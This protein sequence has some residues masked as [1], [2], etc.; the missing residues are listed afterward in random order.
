VA[1]RTTWKRLLVGVSVAA[2]A[3]AAATVALGA[4]GGGKITTI[5]GTSNVG[6]AGGWKFSG[7]GGPATRANLAGPHGVA[8]DRQ[9]NVYV[10]DWHNNRVRKIDRRGIITTFAGR[11][12]AHGHGGDG[13][14]ANRADLAGPRD[15]AVDSRGNVYIGETLRVRRVSPDGTITTLAGT[16]RCCEAL[17][18]GG[19]ATAAQLHIAY[20]L[21]VDAAG[22]VYIADSNTNRVRKVD[23][24]GTIS[25]FAGTGK[26]GFS[27]DGG[28]A[29]SAQLY[30]P[31]DVAVD[32]QG[33]VYIVDR[34]NRR[35][36]KVTPNGRI[37]TVA[38]NGKPGST[39]SGR[40]TAA[41]LYQPWG[42][43][44]D[45]RGI[46]YFSDSGGHRVYRLSGG[47]LTTVAGTGKGGFSGDGKAAIKAKLAYPN[48][49]AVDA[50]GNLYV[51]DQWNNR[52]RKVW[53]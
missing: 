11:D 4:A 41:S 20:G 39:P 52:V 14:P 5:A 35:V 43:A 12:Y 44:I 28:P 32:R 33:N 36:R 16:D 40:A 38:G 31:S 48:G 53:K 10:V 1:L 15:V 51:V 42:I 3:A 45:A 23:P 22:N 34:N 18:D 26:S 25:T 46:V 21:A 6:G 47:M 24:N 29:T 7:D 49:V 37:S 9:G 17:G 13:G 27:G 30:A 50:K 8:V 19:P 2:L